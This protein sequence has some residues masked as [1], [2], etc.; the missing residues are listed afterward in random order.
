MSNQAM[1]GGARISGTRAARAPRA[2]LATGLV[3]LM[4]GAPVFLRGSDR[5][6]GAFVAITTISG[7]VTEGELIGVRE[8]AVVVLT[9]GSEKTFMVAEIENVRIDRKKPTLACTVVGGLA[10]GVVAGLIARR[11]SETDDLVTGFRRFFG[12]P[13]WVIVGAA[14]GAL[15]GI[16][17]AQAIGKD[18]VIMFKDRPGSEVEAGLKAL[19]KEARVPNYK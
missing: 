18:K 10:G 2:A 4:A 8:D 17:V 9:G 11:P 15:G 19:Q 16:G 5:S 3:I 14:A 7:E 12:Y 6:S 13:F 1:K